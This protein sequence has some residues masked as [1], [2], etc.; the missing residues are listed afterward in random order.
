[1]RKWTKRWAARTRRTTTQVI[2]WSLANGR[3]QK[4]KHAEKRQ[5][6]RDEF[7][8]DLLKVLKYFGGAL[9]SWSGP[10]LAELDLATCLKIVNLFIFIF[11]PFISIYL[12]FFSPRAQ[13]TVTVEKSCWWLDSN[14]WSLVEDATALPSGTKFWAKISE[15]LVELATQR[16]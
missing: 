4:Q 13:L 15:R 5:K 1:M 12:I 16:L 7:K 8:L 10:D 11:I 14:R 6:D 3:R 9:V 2:P